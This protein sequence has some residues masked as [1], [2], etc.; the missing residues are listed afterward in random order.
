MA[1]NNLE[2]KWVQSFGCWMH[3]GGARFIEG[4]KVESYNL[5]ALTQ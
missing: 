3:G 2:K 1:V 4:L 5:L